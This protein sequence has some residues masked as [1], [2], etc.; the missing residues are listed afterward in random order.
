MTI[1]QVTTIDEIRA[2]AEPEVIEIPGFKAGAVIHVAVRMLDL[3]PKLLQ[4]R[5]GNPL[6]A[7]AQKLAQEGLSKEDIAK[8]I[9]SGGSMGADMVQLLDEVTREALVA[10]TYEEIT[11]ICPMTFAQKLK[12]F[13]HVTGEPLLPFRGE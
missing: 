10:P 12:V 6:L 1:K 7:E 8:R 11:A 3:T 2:Q 5:V 4:L 13:H 9:D